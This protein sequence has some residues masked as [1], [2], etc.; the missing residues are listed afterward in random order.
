VLDDALRAAGACEAE[1]GSAVLE[2]FTLENGGGQLRA[3]FGSVE[4]LRHRDELRVTD[5]EPLVA[6]V[7]SLGVRGDLLARFRA[8]TGRE[9]ATL[10]AMRIGKDAGLF[11]AR[12]GA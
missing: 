3:E 12:R 10:G 5:V 2:R 11:V 1:L 6:Y 7:A 8:R 9:I 4:T